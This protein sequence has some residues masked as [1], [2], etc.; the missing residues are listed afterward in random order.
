MPFIFAH[1]LS[2]QFKIE[3]QLPEVVIPAFFML[4]SF[5]PAKHLNS[6][7]KIPELITPGISRELRSH[8]TATN[9]GVTGLKRS[10]LEEMKEEKKKKEKKGK[11]PAHFHTL[12]QIHLCLRNCKKTAKLAQFLPA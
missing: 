2:V 7:G 1:M 12:F 9:P 11:T 4:S 8:P 5:D 10:C 6:N 3:P